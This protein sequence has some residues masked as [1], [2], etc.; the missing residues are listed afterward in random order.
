MPFRHKHAFDA[1]RFHDNKQW[2]N[3]Y[4]EKNKLRNE[5]GRALITGCITGSRGK[6]R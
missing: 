3:H 5:D 2:Y 4:Q 6:Q 1:T